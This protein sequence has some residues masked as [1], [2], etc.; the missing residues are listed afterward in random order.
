MPEIEAAVEFVERVGIAVVIPQADL[1]LPGLWGALGDPRGFE[2]SV[3]DAEGDFVA[4]TEELGH[5]WRWKD[6]LPERRLACVGRHLGRFVAV[7]APSLVPAVYALRRDEPLD[8]LERE[9]ADAV[10]EQGPCGAPE[11]RRLLGAEAKRVN[12]AV[13]AL[14]RR[15]VLTSAGQVQQEHGWPAIRLDL[16]DRR[17]ARRLRRLPEPDEARRLLATRVL[18]AAGEAS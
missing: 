18:S 6:E 16:F 9:L 10:H 3:R 7:I 8:G 2:L 11:L 4:W 13:E 12:R 15:C 5:A 1:V 17:W 14:Q